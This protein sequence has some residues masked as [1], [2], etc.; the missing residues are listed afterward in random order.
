[1]NRLSPLATRNV[2]NGA[3]V[4]AATKGGKVKIASETQLTFVLQKP[5]T[6]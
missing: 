1:M 3:A 4:Q 6:L 2:R 5:V